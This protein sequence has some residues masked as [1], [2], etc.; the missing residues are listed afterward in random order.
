M[1]FPL[2]FMLLLTSELCCLTRFLL[3][4][5]HVSLCPSGREMGESSPQWLISWKHSLDEFLAASMFF[6]CFKCASFH[7]DSM[8]QS[9]QYAK[10]ACCDFLCPSYIH[11]MHESSPP[12]IIH[13]NVPNNL[14]QLRNFAQKTFFYLRTKNSSECRRG[15]VSFRPL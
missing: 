14:C 8:Q 6:C 5:A 13:R 12:S 11:S 7:L 3:L 4:C 10:C 2:F 9:L 1:R 15:S